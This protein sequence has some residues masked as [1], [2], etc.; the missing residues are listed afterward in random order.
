MQELQK[1]WVM[2]TITV[3]SPKGGVGK[4]TAAFMLACELAKATKVTVIDADPNAPIAKWSKKGKLDNLE[5]IHVQPKDEI[6]SLIEDAEKKAVFVIVDTE[7][8]AD[9]RVAEAILAA[10]FVIVPSQG[11]ALD[12]DGADSAINLIRRQGKAARRSIPFA[13]LLTRVPAAIHTRE[14]AET[15]QKL[16]EDGVDVFE[17]RIIERS[18]FRA[19]FK[20]KTTLDGLNPSKVSNI[21]KAQ[22]NARA[23]AQ[24]VVGRLKLLRE[25]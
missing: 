3:A 19:I 5:I 4:S 11:S 15:E 21:D 18:A 24:E 22:D 17:T 1:G 9:L 25:A 16:S 8:V 7:G 20:F 6:V 12:Q 14:M 2:P 10:D 13:V 23:F